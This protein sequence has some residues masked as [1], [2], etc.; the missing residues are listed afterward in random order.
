MMY[1]PKY[2]IETDRKLID[3]I[4]E[5]YPFATLIFQ[6]N[7][8]IEAFHLP[9]VLDNEKLIGHM[10][11]ANPAW[12]A[13]EN[14]SILAIFHGPHCFIS[15]DW[16]G[17]AGNV[18][19]WNYISIHIKGICKVIHDNSFL[20]SAI[21]KLGKQSDSDFLIEKNIDD[22][23]GLLNG[24]VGIEITVQ[25]IFAKFKLAQSKSVEER[26][27]VIN[28]LE[29]SLNTSDQAVAKAMQMTISK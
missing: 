22:H 8:K 15:P 24:V 26:Q 7:D 18:P 13:I 5:E 9:L 23:D 25:D 17:K 12:E 14:S 29:K 27:N 11:K 20:K 21:I 4:I 16:Y 2:A 28:H 3:S 10:A 19:T 1:S 6:E